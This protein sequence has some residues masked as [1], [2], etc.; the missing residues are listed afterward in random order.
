VFAAPLAFFGDDLKLWG[1]DDWLRPPS[2]RGCP[3]RQRLQASALGGRP[4]PFLA[5]GAAVFA[6]QTEQGLALEGIV[7]EL[8]ELVLCWESGSS[9]LSSTSLCDASDGIS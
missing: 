8:G 5:T 7:A 4:G 9:L 1:Q 6:C 3:R 2:P